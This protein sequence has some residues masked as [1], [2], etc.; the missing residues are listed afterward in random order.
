MT[1]NRPYV[2]RALHE[3]IIDNG[4]TPYVLVNA[5]VPDVEVPAEYIHDGR[6][7]LNI[8]QTAVADLEMGNDFVSFTA[9]F[10]G[11]PMRVVLPLN[12][13]LAIYA[14][15]NG[16]GMIFPEEEGMVSQTDSNQEQ[17]KKPF[18]KIVK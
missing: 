11:N 16:K 5:G 15:E 3:W 2:L 7:V 9:R 12:A 8:S 1:S 14:K 13:I 17:E 4:M 6:V 10:A 18:L